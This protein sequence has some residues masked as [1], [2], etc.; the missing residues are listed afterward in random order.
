MRAHRGAQA[1]APARGE[2]ARN[3]AGVAGIRSRSGGEHAARG[4]ERAP[5]RAQ[6]RDCVAWR[7]VTTVEL[8]N[9]PGA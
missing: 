5:T 2:G 8:P 3:A 6:A 4:D 1:R 7:G 9:L